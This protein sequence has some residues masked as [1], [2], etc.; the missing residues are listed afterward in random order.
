MRNNIVELEIAKLLPNGEGL[1][2]IGSKPFQVRNALPGESV[3][4]RILKKR[5]GTRYS[6]AIE[7]KT[8]SEVRKKPSCQYFPRCGGCSMLHMQPDAE[9]ELKQRKL[10][11]DLRENEIVFAEILKKHHLYNNFIRILVCI[12]IFLYKFPSFH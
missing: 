2:S 11:S 1:S 12:I 10:L 3:S 4:A 9:I 7:I 5:K 8:S 6:D